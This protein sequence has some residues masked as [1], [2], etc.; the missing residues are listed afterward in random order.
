MAEEDSTCGKSK[1]MIGMR[2]RR[3]SRPQKSGSRVNSGDAAPTLG[4]CELDENNED[5]EEYEDDATMQTMRGKRTTE[6]SSSEESSE[7]SAIDGRR[8]SDVGKD[9]DEEDTV[10]QDASSGE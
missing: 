3:R 10:Q 5:S 7:D 4:A 8:S 6:S 9:V 1:K 2:A